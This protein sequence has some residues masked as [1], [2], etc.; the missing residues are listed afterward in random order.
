MVRKAFKFVFYLSGHAWIDVLFNHHMIVALHIDLRQWLV[1]GRLVGN[2]L[3]LLRGE[4]LV[5]VILGL[6]YILHLDALNTSYLNLK[7]EF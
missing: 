4:H 3:L 7:F 1:M 6:I 5:I 2:F